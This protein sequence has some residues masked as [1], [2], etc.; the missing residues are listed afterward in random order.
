MIRV[1]SCWIVFC[2]AV[3]IWQVLRCRTYLSNALVWR[4]YVLPCLYA[5]ET[6]NMG[7]SIL[8]TSFL[9]KSLFPDK[10]PFSTFSPSRINEHCDRKEVG[11]VLILQGS[12][13]ISRPF[14][15][16]TTKVTAKPYGE[17]FVT[18]L[19]SLWVCIQLCFLIG[20]SRKGLSDQLQQTFCTL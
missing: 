15:G 5:F 4:M 14:C 19:L 12:W 7:G 16:R 8:L 20:Y 17:T 6:Q 9:N 11:F 2:A 13:S 1:S 3:Q 10:E 18:P